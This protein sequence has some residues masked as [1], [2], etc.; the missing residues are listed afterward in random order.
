LRWIGHRTVPATGDFAPI[1]FRA[2]SFGATQDLLL[3]PQHRV[4]VAHYWA[5]LLFGEDEVLVKAKDLVNDLG[6]RPDLT[7]TDVTYYHLLLDTHHVITA[8]GV[9]CESYLPGPAMQHQFDDE[10]QCEIVTLF[11]ELAQ[12]YDSY[13]ASARTILKSREATALSRA[14]AA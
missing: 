5:Q 2:G 14:L 6:I 11:P 12:G 4:L 1:R 8:N 9:P 13:G 7:L 3:S 10:T